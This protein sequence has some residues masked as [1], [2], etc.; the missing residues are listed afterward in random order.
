[1][2]NR[3]DNNRGGH[4]KQGNPFNI[5][6]PASVLEEYES[7]APGSVDGLLDLAAKEQDHR[8]DWQ[9]AHLR[10]HSRI[11]KWGQIFAFAYNIALLFF[12]GHLINIGKE[13]LGIKIF[14]INAIVLVLALVITFT[15]RKIMNRRTPR[16]FNKKFVK[17]NDNKDHNSKPHHNKR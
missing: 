2:N 10:I 12:V 4:T 8:H 5:L 14:T 1:M 3:R 7:I 17:P 15:E 9:E 13:E 6:P 16:K 11:Y